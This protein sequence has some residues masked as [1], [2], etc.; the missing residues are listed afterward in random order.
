MVDHGAV[1]LVGRDAEI[2]LLY[3]LL[4]RA[5]RQ[6][7]ALLLS[8]EPGVGK[9]A[10]LNALG[11]RGGRGSLVLRAGGVEFEADLPYSALIRPSMPLTESA[12]LPR[13]SEM[14]SPSPA[15]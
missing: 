4:T 6:G 7:E 15:A 3:E 8:G 10:L 13:R 9:T 2:D 1:S 14:P 12:E 11:D 5:G